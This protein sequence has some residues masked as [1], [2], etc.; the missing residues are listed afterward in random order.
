MA[1]S[2]AEL[3]ENILHILIV[4]VDLSIMPFHVMHMLD[5][6]SFVSKFVHTILDLHLT[7]VV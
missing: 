5:E 4:L 6:G 7:C 3:R 1:Y 2:N